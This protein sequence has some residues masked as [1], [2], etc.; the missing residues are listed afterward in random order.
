MERTK[1]AIIKCQADLCEVQLD[2]WDIDS[3]FLLL[4]K[5][6]AIE[7]DLYLLKKSEQTDTDIKT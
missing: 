5:E 3:E 4:N 6:L 7:N 2:G 1:F